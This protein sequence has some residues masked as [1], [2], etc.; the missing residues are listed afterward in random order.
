[1]IVALTGGIGSGKTTIAKLLET[2]GCVLYNSDEKA[3]ELYY[4][5]EV[6]KQVINLLSEN[7]YS[8]D[9]KL[10]NAYVSS[11]I[12]NDSDKLEKLNAIIHPALV[13]DFEN[14]VK[15]QNK[16]SVI[17]KESALIFETGLYKKFENII[18]VIAPIEQKI[19]R[20][21]KRNL[22]SREE[23]EQRMKVQWNDE[24]KVPLANYIIS[25]S[26]TDAIIPQ[27]LDILGKLKQN[28]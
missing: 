4:N 6:K 3:K 26:D 21:M 23:V 1:M 13:L 15:K 27:A 10:N 14:F 17:I 9:N 25:N 2:M 12:F 24:K 7:T 18:L 19:N 22:V 5:D 20:V 8:S 11:I 28:A 16:N